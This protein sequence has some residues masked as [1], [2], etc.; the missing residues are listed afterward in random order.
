MR[1]N[2]RH[3]ISRNQRR[4]LFLLLAL[5]ERGI[6]KP[7][8]FCDL[9]KMVNRDLINPVARQNFYAGLKTARDNGLLVVLRDRTLKLHA[10]LTEDGREKARE[11]AE[12]AE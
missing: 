5:E 1:D 10:A 8:P 4:A 11:I 2:V 6:K 3:R 9:L 12:E 7:I